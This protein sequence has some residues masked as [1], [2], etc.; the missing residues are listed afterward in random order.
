[1]LYPYYTQEDVLKMF[2]PHFII[3]SFQS[4]KKI[5]TN[6]II[7]DKTLN[8]AA[9]AYIDA[10]TAFAKVLVN[11]AID[12]SKMSFENVTNAAFPKKE[13]TA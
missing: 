8:K 12:I 6:A 13:G 7:T 5:V 4:T 1:M 11:N 3:D 10:Q 9:N 2:T